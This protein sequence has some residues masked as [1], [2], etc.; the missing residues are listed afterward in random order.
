MFTKL[1]S[2]HFLTYLPAGRD[3][4]ILFLSKFYPFFIKNSLKIHRALVRYKHYQRNPCN[5]MSLEQKDLELIERIIHKTCDDT[6]VSYE[7]GLERV[8]ERLDGAESRIYSRL[9]DI[10]EKNEETRQSIIETLESVREDIREL[11][12]VEA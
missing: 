9:A 4:F 1:T 12:R 8:E 10:E 2:C 5:F 11:A 3:F 6:A 7:R